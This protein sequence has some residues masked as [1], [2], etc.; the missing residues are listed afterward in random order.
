MASEIR[1]RTG[2]N[3]GKVAGAIAAE[4]RLGHHPELLAIGA[5]AVT[6]AVQAVAIARRF[7]LEDNGI[8]L[9]MVPSF[10]ET[11]NTRPDRGECTG[12]RLRCFPR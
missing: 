5:G 3:P 12:M 7:V 11:A 9:V 1:V 10:F 6:T 4:A 8:D 2:S